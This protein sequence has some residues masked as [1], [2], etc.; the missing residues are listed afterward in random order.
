MQKHAFFGRSYETRFDPLPVVDGKTVYCDPHAVG[1]PL[2]EDF[3]LLH[4]HDWYEVGV[5]EA[6]EGLFL[7][8]G[9]Y[10]SV[11]Q[12]DAIF[13]AP[14]KRHYSR[15][16]HG[17]AI[18]RC[19]FAYVE[20]EC[21]RR[22]LRESG[23]DEALALSVAQGMPAVLRKETYP[24][25][26]ALIHGA[27]RPAESLP[28]TLPL[29]LAALLLDGREFFSP[30]ET[31]RVSG[32]DMRS[33][34]QHL[35]LHYHESETAA[36]LA[37]LCHLSESQLRRRFTAVYGMPPVAYR[38]RLRVKVAAELLERTALSV[39]DVAARV[40]YASTSDLYRAFRSV[41]GVSPLA[42]RAGGKK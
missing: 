25:V 38:N 36:R 32:D 4:Y 2:S 21:L 19:R 23:G 34:A 26:V 24:T 6:G 42:Y 28:H 17:D 12:G 11:R 35:A 5:C 18:C 40:G 16:L 10:Y 13:I 33:L 31:E 22:A 7:C 14:D 27:L 9:E 41:Y 1:L 8:E 29:R 15:S 39:S 3:P 37:A 20:G 30:G